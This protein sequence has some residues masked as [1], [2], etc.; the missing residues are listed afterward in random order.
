MSEEVT[1][2]LTDPNYTEPPTVEELSAR[3]DKALV[4]CLGEGAVINATNK[5][6]YDAVV[7]VFKR[8]VN[9]EAAMLPM[10][11]Q[12]SLIA[13]AKMNL[14]AVSRNNE[15]PGGIWIQKLDK[16]QVYANAHLFFDLADAL[17]RKRIETHMEAIFKDVQAKALVQV[18]KDLHVAEGGTIQ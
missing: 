4:L 11:I 8:I 17:G 13:H 1:P 10:G 7:D 9:L 5:P 3:I 2:I 6:L 15:P 12:A 16:I 14:Q 18:E